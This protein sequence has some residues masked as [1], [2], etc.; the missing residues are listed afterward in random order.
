MVLPLVDGVGPASPLLLPF[1]SQ[2]VT[3]RWPLA[4]PS[5]ALEA[6]LLGKQGGLTAP[7]FFSVTY[8]PTY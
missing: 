1:G 2:K 5:T 8:W 3:A 7:T 4:L 6:L